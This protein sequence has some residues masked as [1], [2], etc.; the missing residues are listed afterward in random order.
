MQNT[1][2]VI[3]LLDSIATQSGELHGAMCD[4]MAECSTLS[5]KEVVESADLANVFGHKMQGLDRRHLISWVA[6][7]TPIRVR[8]KDNGQFEKITF[9]AAHVK[10]AK[11]EGIPVWNI[12]AAREVMWYEFEAA[13]TK[14]A[15]SASLLR[16]IKA[17]AREVAMTA[18]E[19]GSAPTA[20]QEAMELVAST[21]GREVIEVIKS[22]KFQKWA[23][24]RDADLEQEKRLLAQVG[25]KDAA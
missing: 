15:T 21:L 6:E 5:K 1:I 20:L 9:S 7:F 10:R 25:M 4:L 12:E 19:T 18:H 22:D 23:S 16:G 11:E 17:L 14:K 3:S 2:R 13:R 24:A 8:T